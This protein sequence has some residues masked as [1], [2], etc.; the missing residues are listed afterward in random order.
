MNY[1]KVIFK[2]ENRIVKVVEGISLME[3]INDQGVEHDF[4]CGG[5]G[6]C[7]KC[8][9]KITRDVAPPTVRELELLEAGEIAEGIRLAC[10]TKVHGEVVVE[11]NNGENLKHN[12]LLASEEKLFE[13]Q[14]HLQK[15]F[16]E[17]EKPALHDQR[18]DWQ[19][20]KD[21]FS[22]KGCGP[23]DLRIPVT[24][25]QRLSA[26]L[27][28]SDHN[29]TLIMDSSEV[30]GIEPYDTSKTMLGMAFDI[31]TTTIVGYLHDLHNGKELS[32]ASILNPQTKFGADVIT[33]INFAGQEE[34]GLHKLHTSVLDAVNRLIGEAARK[35][36]VKRTDIY[37]I[38]VAANTCMH[39][40]FLGINP[41]SIAVAPYVAT[42]S[43]PVVTGA[44]ELGIEINPAGRVFV[45]PNIAGFVG[46][47]TSAVLL[48][49]GLEQSEDIKLVIDI[50]TNGEI[51]L[52]SRAG[53]AACSAAAGPA[54]EGAMISS[55]MRG[56]VGAIDH[57]Y[58][59]EHLEYTIIG[60]GPPKGICGSALLDTIA[61]LV[62]LGI[63]DRRG[64]IL[65][66]D[67]LKRPAQRF[68]DHL[69][70][71]GEQQAFLLVPGSR[72]GHGRPITVTQAD[73]R[74]LQL[75]KGAMAAGIRVLMETIGAELKDIKEV[76]LA[77]AFG[78]Y[79]T[80]HSACAIGLIPQ[81]LEGRIKMIGNAAGTGARMALLSA[82][83]YQRAAEVAGR[84]KFVELGSYPKFN[85]IFA[86]CTYFTVS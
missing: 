51:V 52:G 81:E 33:R 9:V 8:R 83:E 59:G 74:E 13:I 35:A 47:D 53:I 32:V 16:V 18:S 84:V 45:L 29:I 62:E 49:T 75:A 43:E 1:C 77:G 70:R 72:T 22:K 27:R 37:G 50:G 60:G 40:L 76:L 10:L 57:V 4:P 41:K 58:F 65:S 78:N 28:E 63:V 39:H 5:A 68:A 30:F 12:I 46:A 15:I 21:S 44:S 64:K 48:A 19:R 73:I 34:G 2:P 11:I 23:G 42:V 25:F 67:K 7:G 69:V 71:H 61:G 38:S 31:G 55:G 85:S 17:V 56:A 86:E 26:L 3:V 14:P 79:L 20:V 36:G 82:T 24:L 54:F 6:T 80:P 66:A